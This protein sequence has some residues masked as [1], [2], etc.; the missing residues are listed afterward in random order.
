MVSTPPFRIRERSSHDESGW[1][2]ESGAVK[3]EEER[4]VKE[5]DEEV[6]YNPRKSTCEARLEAA[7][8]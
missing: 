7:R 2:S 1:L 5:I 6:L 8:S 4:M 3:V